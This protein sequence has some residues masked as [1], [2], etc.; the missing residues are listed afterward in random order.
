MEALVSTFHL[1]WKMVVA[2]LLNFAIVFFVLYRYALKPLATLM[3]DRKKTIQQGLADAQNNAQKVE[4]INMLYDQ[5]LA[6][7]RAESQK[8][9]HEMKQE[10][11]NKRE[12]LIKKAQSETKALI[13]N[14][15]IEI[16]SQK[17]KILIEARKEIGTLV[18]DSINKVLVNSLDSES[19]DTLIKKTISQ[20]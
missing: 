16:E 10:V 4:E 2:Q 8:L 7:A 19:K 14:A 11:E 3:D 17:K 20:I 1:D 5:E 12:D 18:A 13:E 15:E 9:L 6:R